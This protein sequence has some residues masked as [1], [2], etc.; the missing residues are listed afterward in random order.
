MGSRAISTPPPTRRSC[1]AI[2]TGWK[3]AAFAADYEGKLAELDADGL[4]ECIRRDESD[5][6]R[7]RAHHVLCRAALSSEH[8]GRGR[9]KFLS[10]CQEKI[11]NFTTPLVFFNLEINRFDDAALARMY[12]GT[13]S[14]PAMPPCFGASA[15]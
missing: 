8:H 5:Q 9:A 3:C 11:T 2:S 4:L 14:W 7:R 10:D 6:H 13:P 1:S 12:D 15:R